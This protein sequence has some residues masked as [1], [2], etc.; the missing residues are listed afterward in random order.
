MLQLLSLQQIMNINWLV[1]IT[2][3]FRFVDLLIHSNLTLFRFKFSG[4]LDKKKLF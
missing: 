1:P 4:K 3:K 2:N